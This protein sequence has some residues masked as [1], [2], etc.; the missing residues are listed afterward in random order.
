MKN[1]NIIMKKRVLRWGLS[2]VALL[3]MVPLWGQAIENQKVTFYISPQGDDSWQGTEASPL[4]SVHRAQCLAA[5]YWGKKSL[6]FVLMDGVHYLDSCLVIRP[7]Q[8]GTSEYPVV[9]TAQHEGKAVLSG[10]K[11]I[12]LKWRKWKGEIYRAS[13]TDGEIASIDQLYVNGLRKSMARYPN[14]NGKNVFDAWNLSH[15]IKEN[16][17]A[18]MFNPLRIK[19]WKNPIG[20]YI[21]AMHASLWGDMHWVVTGTEDGKLIYE[22]GWQNNRPSPMHPVYRMIE[23]VFEELD[24]PGEWFF[25]SS[26][27]TLYYIPE[28]GEN[29]K[30][31]E[32][33]CVRL[34]EL[35][36]FEGS[37]SA[38]I[39]NTAFK[40]LVFRHAARTFME[41][42]EPLL[43]SDWTTCRTGAVTF[44]G[45]VKCEMVGCEFDQVGGNAVFVD[46]YN[47]KLL[48]YGC[49]I[50]E[51]GANGIAFV[52]KPSSVRSPLFRYGD[53]NYA[54][55]D[56][57]PGPKNDLYPAD[58]CVEECLLTR[59]GR[60]EK[61]TAPIQISMSYGI[62]VS[63]CSIYDV[64]RAG[65]NISEGTFGGHV[66]EYCDVFNTVLETGDHG[67][68]NSWGRDRFWTPDI[69]TTVAEV[70]NDSA[71]NSLDMLAP[72]ILR[73]NRWR[74]DHGWDID[75]DDGSSH[76][77]IYNNL[78]L[79]GGLKFREGYDRVATNNVI[80][81][82][83][84][85]PHVWY[86]K[87]G[88][89]FKNNLIF[90]AYRPIAMN[91]CIPDE[92]K[93]GELMD[94]NFFVTG[95]KNITRYTANGC[96]GNSLTGDPLF[97]DAA[98]GDFRV[99]PQS[100][101]LK[102]GFRNFDM[103]NFGVTLPHLRS[104]ARTPEIPEIMVGQLMEDNNS[105]IWHKV[106]IKDVETL[107]EQSATGLKNRCGV[108]VVSV[109]EISE[110][111][112]SGLQANDVILAL[113]GKKVC[114]VSELLRA[115]DRMIDGD[116]LV[117]RIWRNQAELSVKICFF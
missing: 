41:N 67:S 32:V 2:V 59:T 76:Y 15:A 48:F 86:A 116:G 12:S 5:P 109:P 110:M 105:C 24:E 37:Q 74:C 11:K 115:E 79:N 64:P 27:R 87:S 88:D 84:L 101:A 36:R 52:G 80:V 21:H 66:I 31:A 23:N 8:S 39:A 25:D 51:S 19:R 58:C 56:R 108:L 89:V 47:R 53:Q 83:S 111:G 16:P 57:T 85:H 94:F 30:M 71:L 1:M 73:N 46:G 50:H 29:M 4:K 34:P 3:G 45:A 7:Y 82:N 91:I 70:K 78:L 104:M 98:S 9:Y 113:N 103:K 68:F 95:D 35:V 22:G 6:Q 61:Q 112:Q 63:H 62:R 44:Q 97:V 93:W 33:E 99:E 55:I 107:G 38:P 106:K 117:L 75:L 81:N 42:R 77:R 40:G 92:G 14:R 28:P 102:I 65:I 18:D 49:Y 100:P 96:D 10:G 90:G 114:E 54:T 17:E 20:A 43:R 26:Q 60:V 72:N 69:K 13:L